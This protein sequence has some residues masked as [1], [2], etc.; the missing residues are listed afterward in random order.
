MKNLVKQWMKTINETMPDDSCVR[1]PKFKKALL[2]EESPELPGRPMFAIIHA[3]A[4]TE[5]DK[6]EEGQIPNTGTWWDIE[7]NQKKNSF[8]S[9]EDALEYVCN[10]QFYKWDKKNWMWDSE[11]QE[12]IGDFLVDSESSEADDRDIE[13]WKQGRK[14][15]WARRISVKLAKRIDTEIEDSDIPREFERA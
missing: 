15:L 13:Q 4:D 12:F 6:W 7:I 10:D 5:E 2:K 3:Y 11:N 1:K 8:S 14:R 9:I